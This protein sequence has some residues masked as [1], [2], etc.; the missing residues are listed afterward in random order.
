MQHNFVR[1]HSLI[2][3]QVAIDFCYSKCHSDFCYIKY[4]KNSSLVKCADPF[5]A[6]TSLILGLV[7][8]FIFILITLVGQL[9]NTLTLIILIL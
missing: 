1:Q 4:H 3:I 5:T 9:L 2:T 6:L 8:S 7:H